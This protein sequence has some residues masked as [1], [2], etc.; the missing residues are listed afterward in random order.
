MEKM[1][2]SN[3]LEEIEVELDNTLSVNP[4]LD[5]PINTAP[6]TV[7]EAG[8]GSVSVR[9]ENPLYKRKERQNTSKV[10]NDF[11]SITIMG[12]KKSQCHW[13]KRLFV[14]GKSS[15][16]S[17]LNRHLTSCARFIEH[18]SSKKQKTLSIDTSNEHDGVE[19]LIPFSYKESKVREMA[20]HMVLF[21]EYPFNMMEH[22]LFNKFMRVCTPHW[23]KNKSC[24]C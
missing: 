11:D 16:T 15:T 12:V 7:G 23:K 8:D 2:Q 14:V 10:W 1:S 19:S 24:N 6:P 20:V 21:H 22:E 18:N 17:T 9:S 4:K 3:E 13:C 5:Q